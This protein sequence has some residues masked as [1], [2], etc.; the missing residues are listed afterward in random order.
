MIYVTLISFADLSIVGFA[1]STGYTGVI[2][3]SKSS[4][5]S[6]R[7]C[8]GFVDDMIVHSYSRHIWDVPACWYMEERLWKV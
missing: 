4:N 3:A 5:K 6:F 1:F 8:S 2:M 7:G